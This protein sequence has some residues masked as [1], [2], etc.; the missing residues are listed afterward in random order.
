MQTLGQLFLI[1][2]PSGAGKSSLIKALLGRDGRLRVSVSHTTRPPRPGEIDGIHYHFLDQAAFARLGDAGEFLEQAQVFGN[3]YGTA[4]S[5][6]RA[7]LGQGHD[8]ILEIDWQ[9]AR[10]VR[11]KFPE[12][13]SIFILPPSVATLRE[14]LQ[15]RG[16]DLD[17]VIEGR[18]AAAVAELSHY[19]EYDY[20]VVNDRFEQALDDLC[21]IIGA[22]RLRRPVQTV[23]L[24]GELKGLVAGGI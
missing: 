22:W 1:S 18:M 3:S 20:L 14:R 8:L 13:C 17:S 21:C 12:V 5:S 2:A 4:E 15:S 10:Q 9:G 7:A 6:V 11:H 19:P 24:A 16:Q 23:R